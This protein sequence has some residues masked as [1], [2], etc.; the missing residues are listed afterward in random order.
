MARVPAVGDTRIIPG[1]RL[2]SGLQEAEAF[3]PVVAYARFANN[4]SGR[5]SCKPEFGASQLPC[6][7]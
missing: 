3:M 6:W 1:S 2:D 7:R 5:I 4:Q